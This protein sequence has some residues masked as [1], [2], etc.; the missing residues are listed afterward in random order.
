MHEAAEGSISE[1]QEHV[2]ANAINKGWWDG[3]GI[4]L[5]PD[6]VL[7]K[8]ML[9]VT[10]LAEAVELVREPDF[11]PHAVFFKHMEDGGE[12]RIPFV[13]WQKYRADMPKPEGFGT[14]IGDAI[15]RLMDL[16]GAMGVNLEERMREKHAYNLTRPSRHGGK[17]A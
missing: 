6:S 8:I 16:A 13:H 4:A 3:Q 7:A 1:F 11:D 2:H 12:K 10:E 17:R 14:E 9:T 5:S 15:I